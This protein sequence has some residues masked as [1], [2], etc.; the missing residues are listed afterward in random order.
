MLPRYA[1]VCYNKHGGDIMRLGWAKTKYSVSYYIK[2][3]VYVNGKN[4]DLVMKRLGSE[5]Y[6]CETYGVTDAKA[7]AKEQVRLMN[8]AEKEDH[9]KFNIELC[10][11]TDLVMNEQRRFNGGYLFLQDIYYELG[12][13]KICR[14]ISKR[15]LFEYDL[16]DILSRLIYTRILYP[17]SKKSSFEEAKRFI[18]QPSFALHDIYR[19]LSVIAQESDYIQSR[20][21]KNSAAIQKRNTQVIYYDCTNF[22]FEVDAAEE[23][24]QFG[25]SKENRPLPIV[26]MGLFMDMDGIPISFSI[27]P[28]NRNE[29]VTMIPLEEKM[30]SSFEL[31]KFIVCTDAGLSSAT[32]RVFNTYDEADGLRG[33]ITTQPIKTLKDF[34]QEWCMADDGW[35]LDGDTSGKNYKLSE[36]DD[37][38]DKDKIFYKTRWIKEEGTV[39][40]ESGDKKQIIEQKLIVSYSIKYRNYMRRI[41]EGQIERARKLVESGEKAINRKKQNDPK[42]FIKTDHATRE[43]EAAEQSISYIDQSVIDEEARYDGF[44]A[45]CTNLDDSISSIVKA[46]KRRWEIEECFRIMKTDFEARPVY[47]NRQ[48]R[49]LAHFI[50]CF[51]ALIV[52]RYLERKLD[53]EYTIEQIL[54]TLQEMDF[55]K[56]EGKGYQP[57]Y[58]RTELTDALHDAF[59]FCTSKQ[60][61]PIAKMK[62]FCSQTK[63]Q[64]V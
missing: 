64:I 13:H 15:H 40:S 9:A 33:Y 6:I 43:G 56:Y 17:S 55:M 21:F 3:T 26:G 11:G 12:L 50:T 48:D 30:L 32:N 62:N 18:E 34:L 35:S 41:R 4:K 29:Q 37:E 52:Y 23:D 8:E 1:K 28:G 7:W 25:K 5:K 47:L 53:N 58:T 19:A 59:G 54:P 45:V 2:K 10:A 44:Y 16:N 14:A 27:Y 22:Y 46:N 57:V 63:K 20:L 24:K 61:V 31:S 49:I 39:H 36:L 42:R 60:I 51:I 38:Q